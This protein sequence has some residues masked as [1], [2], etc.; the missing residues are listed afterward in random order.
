MVGKY[1]G[2]LC[3]KQQRL[4]E[5][6]CD[7]V[8]RKVVDDSANVLRQHSSVLHFVNVVDFALRTSPKLL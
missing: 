5:N 1:T 2:Q 7:V 6:F 4:V 3:Q 8:V